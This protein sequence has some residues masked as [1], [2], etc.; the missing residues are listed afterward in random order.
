[1]TDHPGGAISGVM[2]G[3]GRRLDAGQNHTLVEGA[4]TEAIP[5][6]EGYDRAL[7]PWVRGWRPGEVRDT[8]RKW[9]SR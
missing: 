5:I 6:F 4:P 8:I 3:L 1:M 7:H 2:W 9:W